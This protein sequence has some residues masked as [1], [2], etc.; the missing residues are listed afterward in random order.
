MPINKDLLKSA[1]QQ[2]RAAR[3]KR[4]PLAAFFDELRA[5]KE[6]ADLTFEQRLL[7]PVPGWEDGTWLIASLV[8][9]PSGS[10]VVRPPKIAVCWRW[11]EPDRVDLVPVEAAVHPERLLPGP[12]VSHRLS[13]LLEEIES[14]VG[15]P[16]GESE[17]LT[18]LQP[19]YGGLIPVSFRPAIW[20]ILPS[21]K[22]W[23]V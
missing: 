12:Q 23:L 3:S 19:L 2:A 14:L 20:A 11:P 17:S 22:S 18:K 15:M 16:L 13:R 6:L 4:G 8:C 5:K 10:G 21:S 1:T 9:G 7:A